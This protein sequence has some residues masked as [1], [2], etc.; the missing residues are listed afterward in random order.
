MKKSLLVFT[1]LLS[2]LSVVAQDAAVPNGVIVN[3]GTVTGSPS[4]L[5]FSISWDKADMPS[6]WSDSVWILVD[7][8]ATDNNTMGQVPLNMASISVSDASGPYTLGTYTNNS[9]GFYL[10]G[11]AK[12]ATSG[13][14]S[15]TVKV[16]A[17]NTFTKDISAS[18][19]CVYALNY[20]PKAS[21]SSD[22]KTI[23]FIGTPETVKGTITNGDDTKDITMGFVTDPVTGLTSFTFPEGYYLKEFTDATGAP[24][25]IDCKIPAAPAVAS[26]PSSCGCNA[27]T[28]TASSSEENVTLEWYSVQAGGTPVS[29]DA[30]YTTDLLKA[31]AT[32]YAA[33]RSTKG[34]CVSATRT[35]ALAQ[36][37]LVS[38]AGNLPTS[39]TWQAGDP[40]VTKAGQIGSQENTSGAAVAPGVIGVA[41]N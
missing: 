40:T 26:V 35:S 30:S 11:N 8:R 9:R 15:A 41:N 32:F 28:L 36:V 39:S 37:F 19:A 1:L 31:P 23:T 33:A 25:F 38:S 13:S 12:T 21:Y 22:G 29:T 6:V 17:A 24:G 18:G 16:A 20:P 7:H 5:T 34:G 3:L 14:F 27:F 2:A 4:S 10:V